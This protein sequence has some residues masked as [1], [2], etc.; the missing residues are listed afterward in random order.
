LLKNSGSYGIDWNSC[1]SPACYYSLVQTL[2]LLS[3]TDR[4]TDRDVIIMQIADQVK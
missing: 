2:L 1:V 3:Q 4:Q